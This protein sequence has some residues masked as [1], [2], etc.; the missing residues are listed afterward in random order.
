GSAIVPL[1]DV[2]VGTIRPVLLLLISGAGLLLL[3]AAV[4]VASL[5]LVRSEGRRRELAVRTALGA[6]SARIVAQFVTEGGVLVAI[7]SALGL[8]TAYWTIGLLTSLIPA[9]IAAKMPFLLDLGL[10]PRVFGFTSGL[11]CLAVILFGATPALRVRSSGARQGLTEGSRG[12][13]GMTWHRLAS[14]LVVAEIGA[15]IVLLVGAGLLGRS[16]YRLL[17]VDIGLQADRLATVTV[18]APNVKYSKN[19]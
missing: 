14:K 7:G 18:T 3:L 10:T 12:T 9:N 4:N 6:S 17:H 11:A 8:I 13:S 16:L 19:E 2:I 5:L 15:A 1:N